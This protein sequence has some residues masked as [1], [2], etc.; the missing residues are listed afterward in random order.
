MN[1]VVFNVHLVCNAA[2][3]ILYHPI[4]VSP[5]S[6]PLLGLAIYFPIKVFVR[7]DRAKTLIIDTIIMSIPVLCCDFHFEGP[8]SNVR[9]TC[10]CMIG[11]ITV[12]KIHRSFLSW[13]QSILETRGEQDIVNVNY[14]NICKLHVVVDRF[15]TC[16]NIGYISVWNINRYLVCRY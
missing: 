11:T 10:A 13:K 15:V 7:A 9:A 14:A 6:R 1:L 3:R 4:G 5:S 16:I 8:S 12:S 2:D